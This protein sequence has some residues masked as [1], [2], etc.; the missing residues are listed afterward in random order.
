[1]PHE[2]KARLLKEALFASVEL[3]HGVVVP[4]NH[5][6]NEP[7]DNANLVKVT[8]I[9]TE[10]SSETPEQGINK[11]TDQV[12]ECCLVSIMVDSNTGRVISI[13]SALNQLNDPGYAIDPFI[14]KIT[15]ITTDMVAGKHIDK[16]L[17]ENFIAGTDLI[18]AHNASFDKPMISRVIPS[19]IGMNWGC[20]CSGDIDWK[21]FDLPT[22]SLKYLLFERGYFYEAHRATP[23][24]FALIQL[25]TD[26]PQAMYAILRNANKVKFEIRDGSAPFHMKDTFKE[27]GFKAHYFQG[28]FQYW[29]LKD[30][31]EVRAKDI[32]FQLGGKYSPDPDKILLK[33]TLSHKYM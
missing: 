3:P 27:M 13:E 24:V 19:M 30:I 31:D 2:R 26:M 7:D 25:M 21:D 6:L 8:V 16:A 18:L 20:S 5:M 15:G 29:Y 32:M 14:T 12:I 11:N 33:Q 23:D 1:M 22:K 4:I 9:D 10:T 28:K 17:T